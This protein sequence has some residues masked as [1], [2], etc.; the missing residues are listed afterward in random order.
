MVITL[1]RRLTPALP[2]SNAAKHGPHLI[3]QWC[4]IVELFTASDIEW[5]ALSKQLEEH[6][7]DVYLHVSMCEL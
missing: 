3:T 6:R 5:F 2:L 4:V 1:T 7:G